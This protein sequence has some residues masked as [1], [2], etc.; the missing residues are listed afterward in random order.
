MANELSLPEYTIDY[1]LPVITIN[2]FDQLKTAVEAYAN[3]YQGMAVTASTEK[4]SK[5]SRA[6]LRK[7]KQALDD[8]RKEIRKK[9]AEPYQRFAAQI[10]DLEMTLDSSINPIDA[11]LKEL[12]EQQR[13]TRL[14]HVKALIAEMLEA[15]GREGILASEIEIDP[16]W[17]NKS[18]SKRKIELALADV[19]G[20]IKKQHDD[21]K[22]GISTITKYAQAYQIDPAGWIDQLKQGQDVNYLLQAIDNQV[23]LNQ[24][25]EQRKQAQQATEQANEIKQ[26]NKTVNKTTGEVISRDVTLTISATVPQMNRLKQF[27]DSNGIIYR[28]VGK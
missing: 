22:T 17:L 28:R 8:K 6:E 4:E 26:G 11:G 10:K 15:P 3:K 13:Q 9:Y 20:Y 7:L 1:Q 25:A 12:E 24:E 27:M 2:N 21:L 5:S 23:K 19:M 18:T 14:E 16:T